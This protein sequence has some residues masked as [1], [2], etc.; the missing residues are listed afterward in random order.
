MDLCNQLCLAGRP[1]ILFFVGVIVD[2]SDLTSEKQIYVLMSVQP[3][4]FV[5]WFLS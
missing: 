4:I 5:F 2:L 1:G 3:F